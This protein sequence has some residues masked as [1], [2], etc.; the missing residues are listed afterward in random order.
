MPSADLASPRVPWKAA[1]LGVPMTGLG[2]LYSGRPYRALILHVLSNVVGVICVLSL[3]LHLKPWNIV[4]PIAGVLLWWIL[5]LADAARCAR[6]TPPD[7]R[8]KAYNRWYVY[9]LLIVLQGLGQ[10]AL[11]PFIKARF[12]QAFKIPVQ[13]MAPTIVAGD[14]VLVDKFTFAPQ[15][16]ALAHIL[17]RRDPRRGDLIIFKLTLADEQPGHTENYVKRVIGLP[18][19]HIRIVHREVFINGQTLVE[20]Y[21]FYDPAFAEDV[22]PGDDFPPSDPKDLVAPTTSWSAKMGS[23]VK[24]GELI[25]PPEKYFVLGDNR[26]QSWDSRF[27]GF[28][29]RADILGKADVIYFSW[30]AKARR[31][32]WDRIGEILK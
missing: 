17:P 26:E 11:E 27:W 8:L 24:D 7:Y 1:L 14:H 12:I 6:R 3:F 21:A 5:V 15:G 25:V 2:Q 22:R 4:I 32:R 9:L 13:S 19:D 18:G 31:I 28:V 29:P 16:G 10:H 23:M 30:D 20:P